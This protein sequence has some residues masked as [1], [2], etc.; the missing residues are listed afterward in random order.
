MGPPKN[1]SPE[2]CWLEDYFPLE[3]W[4]LLK[5]DEFVHFFG[6]MCKYIGQIKKKHF[7]NLDFLVR[8]TNRRP[9][10]KKKGVFSGREL[11]L[12]GKWSSHP[13]YV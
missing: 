7:T 10:T 1:I 4:S 3:S 8:K 5:G 12:D 2:K 11:H 6:G 13:N 9:Q